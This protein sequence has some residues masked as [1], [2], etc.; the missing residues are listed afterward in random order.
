MRALGVPNLQVVVGERACGLLQGCSIRSQNRTHLLRSGCMENAT[1]LHSTVSNLAN[2][3]LCLSPHVVDQGAK[4]SN[5]SC[6]RSQRFLIFKQLLFSKEADRHTRLRGI[7]R[8]S[9]L[10]CSFVFRFSAFQQTRV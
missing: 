10:Y 7:G 8:N 4:T 6:V 3:Q 5:V 9:P 2:N 1:T